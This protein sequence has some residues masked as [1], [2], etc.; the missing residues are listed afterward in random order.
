[1]TTRAR[2]RYPHLAALSR[3]GLSG[4]VAEWPSVKTEARELLD[5][6]DTLHALVYE[7]TGTQKPDYVL[8]GLVAAMVVLLVVGFLAMAR[9]GIPS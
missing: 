3:G 8:R 6:A 9:L 5:E 4:Y 1:M 7:L 2:D